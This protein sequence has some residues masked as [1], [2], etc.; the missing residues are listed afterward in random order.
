[1][2]SNAPDTSSPR[3]SWFQTITVGRRPE[4]TFIRILIVVTLCAITFPLVLLPI[5]ITGISMSPTYRDRSIN[6][7]NRLAYSFHEPRR[8]DVV[9]IRFAGYHDTYMKRIVGL[10]GE[11][12]GFAHGQV[13]INGD[14]LPEP[15]EHSPCD[16]DVPTVQLGPD[17]YY[18]VGDNRTMPAEDHVFGKVLRDHIIG[19]VLL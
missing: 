14:P 1:M 8:G 6:V 18:V 17:E 19:R 5:R 3:P 7:V 4:Y 15:Y 2:A 11:T 9:S 10:P 16:W 12:V 13:I